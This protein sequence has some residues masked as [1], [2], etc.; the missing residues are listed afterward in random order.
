MAQ[1][2]RWDSSDPEFRERQLAAMV[3]QGGRV[4]RLAEEARY[5]PDAG[6]VFDAGN[7]LDYW[8]RR[9]DDALA[10][11]DDALGALKDA[12]RDA[13]MYEGSDRFPTDRQR[14]LVLAV[15]HDWKA[16]EAEYRR[17]RGLRDRALSRVE[18]S[19][20]IAEGGW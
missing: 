14:G 7:A 13:G 10:K 20:R 16:A 1:G 19:Q 3:E 11:W 15:E 18:A 17:C 9:T 12:R 2:S 8:E 5:N 6:S 4:E